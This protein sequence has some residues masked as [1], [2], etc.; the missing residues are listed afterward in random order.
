ME[1]YV[2]LVDA[3]RPQANITTKSFILDVAMVLDRSLWS[4]YKDYIKTLKL[5]YFSYDLINSLIWTFDKTD[6]QITKYQLL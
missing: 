1:F 2:T 5:I 3:W 4:S 6:Y